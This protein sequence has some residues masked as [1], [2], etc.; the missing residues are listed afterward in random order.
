M[1]GGLLEEW[2]PA[3]PWGPLPASRPWDDWVLQAPRTGP[4]TALSSPGVPFPIIVAW[5]IGKLYYDNEK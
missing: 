3:L 4:V 5:A 2:V 1:K